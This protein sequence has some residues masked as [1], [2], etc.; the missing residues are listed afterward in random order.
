[1]LRLAFSFFLIIPDKSYEGS[2]KEL[3][4][5]FL[6]LKKAGEVQQACRLWCQGRQKKPKEWKK[7]FLCALQPRHPM[8]TQ[9][10]IP[11]L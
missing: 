9:D 8:W 10:M 5:S 2:H 4:K 6:S 7:A 11:V 3:Q 1:L